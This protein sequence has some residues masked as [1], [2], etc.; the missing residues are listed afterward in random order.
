MLLQGLLHFGVLVDP[1]EHSGQ[2]I[3]E[4]GVEAVRALE[5]LEQKLHE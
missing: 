4:V 5:G 2:D 1:V 3:L